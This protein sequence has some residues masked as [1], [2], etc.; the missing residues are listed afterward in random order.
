MLK[1]VDITGPVRLE[2]AYRQMYAVC[3]ITKVRDTYDVEIM[4][5]CR[6]QKSIELRSLSLYLKKFKDREILCENLAHQ[7]MADLAALKI[8]RHIKIILHQHA[9]EAVEI[10]AVAAFYEDTSDS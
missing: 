1:L 3:P 9:S 6:A 10:T 8:F 7:I 2:L 4:L 5:T